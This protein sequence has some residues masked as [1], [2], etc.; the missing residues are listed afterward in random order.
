MLCCLVY[1]PGH[2]K[3]YA[4]TVFIFFAG[5]SSESPKC[6]YGDLCDILFY[7]IV[8]TIL[9]FY[10]ILNRQIHLYM[11]HTVFLFFSGLCFFNVEGNSVIS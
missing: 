5:F 1:L 2:H 7:L 8:H 11:K 4:Y 9:L 3:S 6:N 10:Y